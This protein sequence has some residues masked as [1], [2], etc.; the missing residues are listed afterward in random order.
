MK[1]RYY[2][3]AA[4]VLGLALSGYGED[5][6]LSGLP[7]GVETDS[8]KIELPENKDALMEVALK[9]ETEPMLHAADGVFALHTQEDFDRIRQHLRLDSDPA[10][11]SGDTPWKEGYLLL[12]SNNLAGITTTMNVNAVE[13]IV[14]GGGVGEN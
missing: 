7:A 1:K 6:G 13:E 3:A 2:L 9:A 4:F 11:A 12:R 8:D 10:G 14:R 5:V